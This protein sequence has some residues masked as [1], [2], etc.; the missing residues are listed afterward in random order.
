MARSVQ[1]LRRPEVKSTPFQILYAVSDFAQRILNQC[2][3]VLCTFIVIQHRK[4]NCVYT[5]CTGGSTA[6]IKHIEAHTS[7]GSP[8]SPLSELVGVH[9]SEMAVVKKCCFLESKS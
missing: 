6:I 8:T 9:V 4:P 7:S 5:L 3:A 2:P 1:F